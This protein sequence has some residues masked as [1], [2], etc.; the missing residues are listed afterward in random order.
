MERETARRRIILVPCVFLVK[1]QRGYI[2]VKIKKPLTSPRF[3]L[4]CPA[5]RNEQTALA[6]PS[7]LSRGEHASERDTRAREM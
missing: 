6:I 7:G 4:A 1:I 5:E 3:F 2:W